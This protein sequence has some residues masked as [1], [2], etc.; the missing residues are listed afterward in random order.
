M[1]SRR[2]KCLLKSRLLNFVRGLKDKS[3]KSSLVN[4]E[5]I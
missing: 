4:K 3:H 5:L 1:S 2:L